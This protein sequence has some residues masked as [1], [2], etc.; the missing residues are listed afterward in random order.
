MPS[1]DVVSKLDVGE[2]K[3]AVNLAQKEIA[4]RYDFKNSKTSL[5]LYEESIEILA[6]DEVKIKAALDILRTRMA[7]R[8]LGMRSLEVGEIEPSADRLF[9]LEIKLRKGIDKEQGKIINKLVKESGVKVSSA[10]LDEKIRLTAK[11]IDDIQTVWA[12][13]R[14]H[15][16]V[17]VDV[18]MENMKRE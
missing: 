17:T 16:D 8:N 2:I 5:E 3:N 12:L 10:Y 9:K 15:K 14:S 6:P 1:C 4:N 11:K 13:I 18:Q 7:K